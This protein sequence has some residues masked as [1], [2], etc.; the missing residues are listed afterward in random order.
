MP[1]TRIEH[2]L[3]QGLGAYLHA[4]EQ[5]KFVWGENDCSLFAANCVQALTGVDIASDF[6]GR[7]TDQTSAFALIKEITGGTSV[8]DAAAYCAEKHGLTEW[9]FPLQAQRGDLVVVKNG[10]NVIAGVVDSSGKFVAAMGDSTIVRIPL[11]QIQR[12]W[13]V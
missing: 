2:W 6:R 1:L 5:D 12:A 4:H 3:T 9:K 10:E 7:Y 13:K 11:R 8:A